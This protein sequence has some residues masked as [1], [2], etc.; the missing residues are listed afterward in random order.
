MQKYTFSSFILA[1]LTTNY[2]YA[3]NGPK[4]Y[5]KYYEISINSVKPE[6]WL[7]QY[8]NHQKK[9][10]TGNLDKIDYPFNSVG[11]AAKEIE[12]NTSWWPYE[13][14]AYWLDGLA[15]TGYLLDDDK[16]LNKAK[17]QFDYVIKHQ[18]DDGFLG[19]DI[20]RGDG[21]ANQWPHVVL[22]RALMVYYDASGDQ[23]VLNALLNFYQKIGRT[24]LYRHIREVGHI[25]IILWLYQKTGDK[26]LL[27]HAIKI[28]DEGNKLNRNRSASAEQ[29]LS[30][31]Q[32]R[33]HGVTY[34]EAAKL[35]AILYQQTGNQVYLDTSI[36]AYNK[37]DKH[38]MLVDGVN[39]SSEGL[40]GKDPLDSHEA[41][42]VADMTWSLGYLLQSTGNASYADKIERAMFN[43]A[44]GHVTEDFKALQY[45]SSPN[46]LILGNNSNHNH[47]MRGNDS[48]AY[49]PSSWVKC[50]PGNINRAMPNYIARMWMKDAK[51]QPV[52]AMYGPSTATYDINGEELKI[53]QQ[54]LYPFEEQITFKLS[55]KKKITTAL[56]LRIPE[57]TKSPRVYINNKKLTDTLI[58]GSFHT[59]N[60]IFSPDDEIKL[61]LPQPIKLS[62]WPKGGIAVE[63]GPLVYSLKVDTLW[64]EDHSVS[65]SSTHFPAYVATPTSP[66]NYALAVNDD[67]ISSLARVSYSTPTNNP[68]SQD[69]APIQISLPA[70][71]VKNWSLIKTNKVSRLDD[72]PTEKNGIV[73]KWNENIKDVSGE[74]TLTPPLPEKSSLQSRLS[75]DKEWITLIP[76]GATKLRLTIFPQAKK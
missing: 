45:F 33:E 11:W 30:D 70:Y 74:Y 39:S 73:Q 71:K 57:W 28:Y 25:E 23:K 5:A 48:M 14:V 7:K 38:Y 47:Y 61:N 12:G 1:L 26:S 65:Y 16:L 64:T 67:N 15:K 62:H 52:I 50:C 36:A 58:P 72:W 76:Y 37:I 54:T 51:G 46:Q 2:V 20:M 56:T 63:K 75:T 31:K 53:T 8:L 6:G 17:L 68:W 24:F 55:M 40:R 22:F 13:Q 29:F 60:H 21:N 19:A 18:A 4:N 3:E 49:Q 34:N 41:C 59:I 10:L 42:D 43:A 32:V 69:S 66:W 9:G 35:G 44:P 27:S